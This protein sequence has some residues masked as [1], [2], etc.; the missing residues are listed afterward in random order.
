MYYET[1]SVTNNNISLFIFKSITTCNSKKISCSDDVGLLLRLPIIDVNNDD[2][3]VVLRT[4]YK[5]QKTERLPKIDLDCD[6]SC[7]NNFA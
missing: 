5:L 4:V 6:L 7:F 2:I 1:K 3:F